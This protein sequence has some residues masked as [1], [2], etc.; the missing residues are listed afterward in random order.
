MDILFTIAMD[1]S[2]AIEMQSKPRTSVELKILC[3][4]FFQLKTGF[5]LF[6]DIQFFVFFL[7]RNVVIYNRQIQTCKIL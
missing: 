3:R 1:I 6:S 4:Y 5:N 2:F 7:L